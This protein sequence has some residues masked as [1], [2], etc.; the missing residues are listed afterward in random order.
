M[1]EF[2]IRTAI[3]LAII[4]IYIIIT[5]DGKWHDSGI[6]A[7]LVPIIFVPPAA[8][9][10]A[11]TLYPAEKWIRRHSRLASLIIVPFISSFL[12]M[13]ILALLTHNV[14]GFIN[15]AKVFSL[16]G[17]GWGVLWTVTGITYIFISSLIRS[18]SASKLPS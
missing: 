14:D 10:N 3:L 2:S 12:M 5:V 4:C 6:G 18:L 17:L 8:I 16:I 13:M 1:R 9:L 11:I 7:L 15:G